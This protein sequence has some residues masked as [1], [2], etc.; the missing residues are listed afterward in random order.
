MRRAHQAEYLPPLAD[1]HLLAHFFWFLIVLGGAVGFLNFGTEVAGGLA[2]K[3]ADGAG[4]VGEE[5]PISL[6]WRAGW[7]EEDEPPVLCSV[8]MV[9][10]VEVE[11]FG[12]LK[13]GGGVAIAED[14]DYW[15]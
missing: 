1:Q 2:M 6:S 11:M 7:V 14:D 10:K 12:L 15:P 5:L 3:P 13:K 8:S 4:G 9:L